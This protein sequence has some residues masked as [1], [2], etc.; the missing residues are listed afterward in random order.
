MLL[1]AAPKRTGAEDATSAKCCQT[2]KP[3]SCAKRFT[4]LYGRRSIGLSFGSRVGIR[5]I[6][7]IDI[8]G[9]LGIFVQ[10]HIIVRKNGHA[11]IKG[12]KLI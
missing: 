6:E 8:A 9:P 5:N 12:L 4:R 11:R 10:D 3:S 7:V 1:L 2:Q